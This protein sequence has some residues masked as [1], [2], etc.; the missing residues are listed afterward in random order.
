IQIKQSIASGSEMETINTQIDEVQLGAIPKMMAA[1]DDAEFNNLLESL[2]S[3]LE[4][5][6]LSKLEQHWTQEYLKNCENLGLTPWEVLDSKVDVMDVSG[7]SL[8]R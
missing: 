1:K 5:L 2:L 7:L 3:D 8:I 4:G 6:G